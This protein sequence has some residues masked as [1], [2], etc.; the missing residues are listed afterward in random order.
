MD[1]VHA[2]DENI[3]IPTLVTGVDFFKTILSDWN[4]IYS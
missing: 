2:L 1:S 3:D 4:K